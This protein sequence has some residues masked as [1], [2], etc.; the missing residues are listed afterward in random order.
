MK[1]R[2]VDYNTVIAEPYD[3]PI[4]GY[5]TDTVNTLRLWKAR[6]PEIII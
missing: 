2:H 5:D 1:F 3:M 4:T 6:S